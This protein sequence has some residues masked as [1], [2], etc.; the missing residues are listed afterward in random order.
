MKGR[1]LN[2][3]KALISLMKKGA[4]EEVIS[5]EPFQ[6]AL[7]VIPQNMGIKSWGLVDFLRKEGFVV[8]YRG[9]KRK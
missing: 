1:Q 4:K 7:K 5:S 2:K 8:L 6:V 3:E 9:G